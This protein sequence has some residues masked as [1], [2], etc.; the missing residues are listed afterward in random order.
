[1]KSIEAFRTDRR[2]GRKYMTNTTKAALEASL[3]K[4]LFEEA[5]GQKLRSTI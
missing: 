2:K 5:A 4:L 3:K 1:M